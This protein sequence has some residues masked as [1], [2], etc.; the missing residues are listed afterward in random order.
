MTA[1]TDLRETRPGPGAAP[2]A[3]TSRPGPRKRKGS[4]MDRKPKVAVA[5]TVLFFV[6]LYLPI[7][8]VVV[9]SFNTRKSL[10]VFQ[11]WSLQ[12]YRAFFHDSELT[13]SLG[14]SL[15]VSAVAMVGSVVLGSA[16]AFGLVPARSRLPPPTP[17]PSPSPPCTRA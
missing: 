14:T 16:L 4:G 17:S 5:V 9:F 2:T 6:L 7:V 3:T 15:E 1:S 10:T 13:H 11:G 12:W 8:A